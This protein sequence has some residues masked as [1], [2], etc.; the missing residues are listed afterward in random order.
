VLQGNYTTHLRMNSYDFTE[1][2]AVERVV[3]RGCTFSCSY[4]DICTVELMGGNMRPLM[5]QNYTVGD[6]NSYYNDRAGDVPE[7]E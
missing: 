5:K 7:K 6:P 4:T 2:D 1:P 3:E